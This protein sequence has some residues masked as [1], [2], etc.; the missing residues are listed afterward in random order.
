M[1]VFFPISQMIDRRKIGFR[2][3]SGQGAQHRYHDRWRAACVRHLHGGSRVV[4][5]AGP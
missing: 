4:I 5:G 1:S 2:V 3:L